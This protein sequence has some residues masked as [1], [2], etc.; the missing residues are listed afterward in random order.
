M[1]SAVTPKLEDNATRQPA[2]RDYRVL[3]SVL[4]LVW[5]GVM[6]TCCVAATYL[7]LT[8]TPVP[9]SESLH[10]GFELW[11]AVLGGCSIY[12]IIAACSD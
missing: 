5:M 1:P 12:L 10:I 4:A 9:A 11:V 3:R 2:G 7:N 8:A 6:V